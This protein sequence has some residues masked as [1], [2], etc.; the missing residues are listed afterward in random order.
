MPFDLFA[1]WNAIYAFPLAL[2]LVTLAVTSLISLVGGAF[3]G[4]ET[5]TEVETGVDADVDADV[6]VEVEA[7]LDADFDTDV[8]LDGDVDA[9]DL[10]GDGE[11]SPVEQATAVARGHGGETGPLVS[12]LLAL[13]VGRAPFGMLLQLLV[14]LWGVIGLAL[15]QAFAVAG[16]VALLWSIPVTLFLSVLVT[17]GFAQ[18]FGRFVKQFETSAV[19]REK[20]VGRSGTVVYPVTHEE[21][22]VTVRDEAGTLHRV[23]ARTAHGALETGQQIVIVGYD[24]D[25][26]LYQVD[27]ASAFVDRP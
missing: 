21:G 3:T 11:I 14:I 27:D 25:S 9:A 23:R 10:D 24:P 26:R 2:V 7:D 6:E 19:R 16:P 12:G 4:G 5:E 22:T 13:G 8:D 17:R 18:L 1:W 15:H 20:I